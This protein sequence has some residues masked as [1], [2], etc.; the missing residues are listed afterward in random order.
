MVKDDKLK[1]TDLIP[2]N[3][4]QQIQDSF[5]N[6]TGMSTG[7]SDENGIHVTTPSH[8]S[9]FCS[10]IRST[11]EGNHRC[12]LCNLNAAQ[13]ILQGGET[14]SYIC[15]AG[16]VD[17]VAPIIADGVLIGC[18][19][20]G[21]VL[22]A[23]PNESDIKG[24][25]TALGLNSDQLWEYAQLIP[26]FPEDKVTKF[27]D[28]LSTIASTVSD[29]AYEKHQAIIASK[30]IEH[31]ATIKTNFFANMSHEIRTPMNAVIGMAEL[32]LREN[33]SENAKNYITQIKESGRALLNIINDILDFSK[34][35][36]GKME[37]IP[38]VYEPLSL[39]NDIGNIIMTRLVE[40]DVLLIL[41]IDPNIPLKLIGDTTRIRQILINLLNNAA[42]FTNQGMVKLS[43]G[44]EKISD[45]TVLLTVCVEDT[46]IGIKKKDLEIIFNS[47]QQVDSKR[48]RNVEGTGLGLSITK[49]L[50]KL[51][52]GN[53]WVESEFGIGSKFYFSIQQ[54]VKDFTPSVSIRNPKSIIA[55][56]FF[57]RKIAQEQFSQ[58]CRL[59]HI[60]FAHLKS[61]LKSIR[62]S[63]NSI[64][65]QSHGRTIYLFMNESVYS[66]QIEQELTDFPA[67]N[68]TVLVDF[69][70]SVNRT[71]KNLHIMKK[72]VSILNF[73]NIFNKED[74]AEYI[75]EEENTVEENFTFTAPEAQILVVDDNSVNLTVTEG[76]LEPLKMKITCVQSGKIAVQKTKENKYDIIFMDHMMPEMD[77]I[78]TTQHI[79]ENP[80]YKSVP[81]IALTANALGNV[82]EKFLEAGLND[83]VAKP[84]EVK[85]IVEKV[86]QWLPPE[87]IIANSENSLPPPSS[88]SALDIQQVP[89]VKALPK[90]GDLDIEGAIKM[91]GTENLFWTVLKDY[92]R[93][94]P[95]KFDLIKEYEKAE[96]WKSYTIEVHA[97]KSSSR[98]IGAT[99]LSEL[100]ARMEQAGN[101]EDA[102]LI[103]EKTPALLEKYLSYIPI[104]RNY[105]AE[106]VQNEPKQ[107][108]TAEQLKD[109]A[110]RMKEANDNL[111]TDTVDKIYEEMSKFS[112]PENK[113]AAAEALKDAVANIDVEGIYRLLDEL[114][115]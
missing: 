61:D 115:S 93:V 76:L 38:E 58:D 32:A 5:S 45:N 51:M 94:I 10:Y 113:K 68:A 48:N 95:K 109:F 36:S 104:L 74:I 70:D 97:L 92:Y 81:I 49:Q 99:E 78:E 86:R 2:V 66:K 80:D 50:V 30:E 98:Q 57:S 18:L 3:Y 14:T 41:D 108:I 73:A 24:V 34:M 90:V 69:Y 8:Q 40:K 111:D 25:A 55:I 15:H 106:K 101:E 46:G 13:K 75:P 77:G 54:P 65:K 114:V 43:V 72:P 89:E 107:E 20:G 35:E 47:F 85:T 12:E 64:L 87:K 56:G 83:F 67:I 110:S 9:K 7:T 62:G 37:L 112:F 88:K 105:C 1:I 23:P 22:T 96:N 4:L 11:P 28:L 29:M 71:L 103:H 52:D 6:A 84:I 63:L 31:A 44:S 39:F 60:A 42:K 17:F 21:Q 33:L 19:G 79:R 59:L 91:L 82:R 102:A 53:I 100:A 16:L 26:T 27:A